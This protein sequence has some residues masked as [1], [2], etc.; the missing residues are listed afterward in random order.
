MKWLMVI[1]LL[2]LACVCSA[3]MTNESAQPL[4]LRTCEGDVVICDQSMT[5]RGYKFVADKVLGDEKI[6][7]KSQDGTVTAILDLQADENIFLTIHEGSI[8]MK[9]KSC[10]RQILRGDEP[11]VASFLDRAGRCREAKTILRQ[12]LLAVNM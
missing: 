11:V 1:T 3:Q 2:L 7:L 5:F 6:A 8:S 10:V 9:V 12:G 4:T